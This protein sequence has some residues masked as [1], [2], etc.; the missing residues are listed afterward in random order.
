MVNQFGRSAAIMLSCGMQQGAMPSPGVFTIVYESMLAIIRYYRRGCTLQGRIAPSGADAFADDPPVSSLHT[1][2]P[3]AIPAMAA[4]ASPAIDYLRTSLAEVGWHGDSL[5]EMWN[6]CYRYAVGTA[7]SNR[8]SHSVESPFLLHSPINHIST[9][10]CV[11]HL[12]VISQTRSNMYA[13][14]CKRG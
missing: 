2:G 13:Q 12:M 14:K 11:L 4:M 1:D 5:E 6:N 10:G 8:V 9:S 3:D 7:S